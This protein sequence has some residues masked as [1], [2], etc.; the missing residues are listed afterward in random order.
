MSNQIGGAD[1]VILVRLM[2]MIPNFVDYDSQPILHQ[3]V[4]CFLL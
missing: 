2:S 4:N 1:R 3:I